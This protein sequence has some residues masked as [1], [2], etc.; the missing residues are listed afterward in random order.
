MKKMI[1]SSNAKIDH[2]PICESKNIADYLKN[3]SIKAG[4]IFF[5]E[6]SICNDCGFYF[7]NPIMDYDKIRG[8]YQNNYVGNEENQRVRF[9]REL[10]NRKSSALSFMDLIKEGDSILEIGCSSGYNLQNIKENFGGKLQLKGVDF[11]GDSTKYGRERTGLDLS[12][13][14]I[15]SSNNKFDFVFLNHVFEHISD[16]KDFF[17]KLQSIVK[18]DGYLIINVP[19]SEKWFEIPNWEHI[20][21]FNE[22]AMEILVNNFGTKNKNYII[23]TNTINKRTH[24]VP[25]IRM[26]F[27]RNNF[28][29][30]RLS[31]DYIFSPYR[32]RQRYEKAPRNQRSM[33]E[34][35]YKKIVKVKLF[36]RLIWSKIYLFLTFKGWR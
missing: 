29:P 7:Q 10:I 9:E 17:S 3:K 34:I 4:N 6:S 36:E 19:N 5:I 32:L 26:I 8:I 1:R 11:D 21:Y 15:F 12:T 22:K 18:D 28:L 25:E 30:S 20:N 33:L 14:D 35:E 31:D 2:C 16:P 13:E 27:T 23:S 24:N